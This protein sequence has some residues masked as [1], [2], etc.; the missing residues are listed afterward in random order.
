MP[1]EIKV[2]AW[3]QAQTCRGGA[4]GM[5]PPLKLEKNM[6]FWGKIVIIHTKY[7][8]NFRVSL[9]SAKCF[10]VRPP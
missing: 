10:Y 6:I 2:M 1:V 8:K 9:R 4:P 5:P 3:G 7:P